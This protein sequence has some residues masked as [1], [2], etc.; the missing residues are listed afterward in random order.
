MVSGGLRLVSE[1]QCGWHTSEITR[2]TTYNTMVLYEV[3]ASEGG[4]KLPQTT[5]GSYEEQVVFS[6]PGPVFAGQYKEIQTASS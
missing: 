2:N 3:G 4:K 1:H 6:G 5:L